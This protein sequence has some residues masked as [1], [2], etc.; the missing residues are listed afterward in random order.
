MTIPQVN[1]GGIGD[2][3]LGNTM[4]IG[5]S[6]LLCPLPEV[7]SGATFYFTVGVNYANESFVWV[8]Q[9]PVKILLTSP[10]RNNILKLQNTLFRLVYFSPP[11]MILKLH[12]V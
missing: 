1:T 12:W 8:G 9:T 4:V 6:S 5:F 2:P 7:V 11:V 10:V 3:G